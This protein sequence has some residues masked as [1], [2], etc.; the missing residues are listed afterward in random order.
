VVSEVVL[1]LLS[2]KM[3][4][5]NRLLA[6]I[7][8]GR[9]GLKFEFTVLAQDLPRLAYRLVAGRR[10]TLLPLALAKQSLLLVFSNSLV[11]FCDTST[12]RGACVALSSLLG[13]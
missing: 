3:F 6:H 1:G 10:Q 8:L 7:S 11:A 13:K 9:E 12:A 4:A 2:N 5:R